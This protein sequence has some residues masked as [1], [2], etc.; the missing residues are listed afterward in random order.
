MTVKE[1]QGESKLEAFMLPN[2]E[3]SERMAKP[4]GAQIKPKSCYD[5]V[6]HIVL[7]SPGLES[8]YP[9]IQIAFGGVEIF[10]DEP[11]SEI[12]AKHVFF[13]YDG[14]V[15][16]PTLAVQGK[17]PENKQYASLIVYEVNEYR[18]MLSEY[19]ETSP[20]H[21]LR[22][23]DQMALSMMEKKWIVLVG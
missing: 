9:G 5:N 2:V 19:G 3:E 23:L 21:V 10:P 15:L 6:A 1:Q 14:K 12:Y 7:W 11:E 20:S 22:A 13:I 16:D 18:E 8:N 17:L 4:F